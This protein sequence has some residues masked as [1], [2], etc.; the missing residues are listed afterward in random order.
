MGPQNNERSEKQCTV[1]VEHEV[2]IHVDIFKR[3]PEVQVLFLGRSDDVSPE[4]SAHP[5]SKRRFRS[6]CKQDISNFQ[7]NI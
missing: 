4:T 1:L 6:T 5:L 3:A 2:S 7:A